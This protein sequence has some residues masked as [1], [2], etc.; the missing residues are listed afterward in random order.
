[1]QQTKSGLITKERK[2]NLKYFD[3]NF[4]TVPTKKY[5]TENH[6][7]QEVGAVLRSQ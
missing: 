5:I 6:S 1:M 2:V 4:L 7:R 3:K